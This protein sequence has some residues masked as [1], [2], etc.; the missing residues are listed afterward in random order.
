M[1]TESIQSDLR[2]ELLLRELTKPI[3]EH[4]AYELGIIDA[5]G[6]KIK[7]PVTEEEAQSYLPLTRTIL[8]IKRHL[9]GKL[10]VITSTALFED[11]LKINYDKEHHKKILTYESKIKN[12]IEEIFEIIESAIN[13]GVT[14]GELDEL[15]QK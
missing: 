15:L 5:N 7:E 3:T 6:N 4:K 13:D 1:F 2:K 10:D 11:V 8:R 9:G 12:K 14:F